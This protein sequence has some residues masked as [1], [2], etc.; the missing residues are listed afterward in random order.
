[1][2][3]TRRYLRSKEVI[4]Y[5]TLL[6]AM[7]LLSQVV[8]THFSTSLILRSDKDKE[9][10]FPEIFGILS[11]ANMHV[12]PSVPASIV[13]YCSMDEFDKDYAPWNHKLE[14][15]V[16]EEHVEEFNAAVSWVSNNLHGV[17]I[18]LCGRHWDVSHENEIKKRYLEENESI[19]LKFTNL[20]M[21]QCE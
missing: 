4:P 1:M 2:P 19:K 21:N 3:D 20:R 5:A 6:Y 8:A 18:T 17:M 10:L 15:Q 9:N 12:C 16:W 7:N 13:I 14:Q 11:T